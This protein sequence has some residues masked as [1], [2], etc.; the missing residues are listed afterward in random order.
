V[1]NEYVFKSDLSKIN[2]TVATRL[3]VYM[4]FFEICDLQEYYPPDRPG[5]ALYINRIVEIVQRT[6]ER[7]LGNAYFDSIK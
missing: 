4:S 1:A 3:C 7:Y 5:Y 6:T 2:Q